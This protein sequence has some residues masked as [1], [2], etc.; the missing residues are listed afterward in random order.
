MNG[1]E[2][3]LTQILDSYEERIIKYENQVDSLESKL[4][5][6]S[7]HNFEEEKRIT[8][9]RLNE[10]ERIVYNWRNQQNEIRELLNAW[11]S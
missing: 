8:N 5:F 4:N 2:E 7:L 10:I 11:L 6:C 1:L 3:K 9:V